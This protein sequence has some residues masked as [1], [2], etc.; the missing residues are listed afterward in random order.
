MTPFSRRWCTRVESNIIFLNTVHAGAHTCSAEFVKRGK[1]IGFAQA[2]VKHRQTLIRKPTE[3][4][5][6]H[7]KSQGS[8]K[9]ADTD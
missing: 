4:F 9:N 5:T 8:R 6:T 7:V 1:S 2:E 3:T